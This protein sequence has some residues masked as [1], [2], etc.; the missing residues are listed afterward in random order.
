MTAISRG[1]FH[2]ATGAGFGRILGFF[3]N[4]LLSRWLG[5]AD[6]GLF[7]L[8]TTTVQTTDTLVRCGADY[9]LN[10]ECGGELHSI[11]TDR[12]A[13][14]ARGL[15]QLCT[16]TTVLACILIGTWVW[17]G[18]GLFPGSLSSIQR[19]S[20]TVLLLLMILC[21][22]I[23]ASAWEILLVSHRTIPLALRSGLFYPLRLFIASLGAL[24]G[25]VFGAMGGWVL[26][27][28]A[29]FFWLRSISIDTWTPLQVW[30]ILS[31]SIRQL[32]ERGFPFYASNLLSSLIF[33]PLLLVV[34][35]GSGIADIG[36]LRVGQILQQLFA[37]LPATL[38]P[39]LFL[40][41]RAQTSFK[42]QVLALEQPLRIIWFVL[43]EVLL[44]YCAFDRAIIS[45]LF[46]D[47]FSSAILPS[48]LLLITA[49]FECLAQLC[50][51]PLLA[52]GRTRA[53]G[54]WQNGSALV[55][56][57]FGWLWIPALGISAYL[58]I[59]LIYVIIPLIGFGWPVLYHFNR[60]QRIVPLGLVTIALLL[61]FISQTFY[62]VAP[63][64]IPLFYILTFFAVG[65]YQR[66]DLL[67]LH[68]TL[69][70]RR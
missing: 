65:F 48:R 21:E 11:Q 34:A 59:R 57:L 29:Q 55:A 41:L 4:L 66:K 56:A 36:Y 1:W 44:I 16:Y 69:T 6:L 24:I 60:L 14:L 37:F 49:L 20:L 18:Q 35:D 46:G 42:D 23:S 25:G 32:L 64:Y 22:C 10:Y 53:Y 43:L 38:V 45:L 9:S 30:P 19:L 70:R 54:L 50:V 62:Q 7:N 67:F 12:G 33:Y 15:S 58:F 2:L 40:K 39:V 31:K 8:V 27:A 17:I 51:Q 52:A 28:I 13:Q 63:T 26:V 5:P 47:D 61:L 68:Q 3:S